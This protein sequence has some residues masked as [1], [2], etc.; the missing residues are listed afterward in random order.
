MNQ[1]TV[2]AYVLRA[3]AQAQTEGRSSTLQTL[4]DELHIRRADVR[5]AVSA[6]HR[7]GYL[8]VMRM[9]LTLQGFAVGRAL[10]EKELPELRPAKVAE[11]AA[12]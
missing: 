10:L 4:I 9:R 1:R 6:L 2:S 8:D 11:A 5:S 12:A 7:E 3:L